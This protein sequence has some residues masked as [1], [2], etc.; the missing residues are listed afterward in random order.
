[1]QQTG[2][3]GRI[4]IFGV[5][6][7]IGI[8][9]A[10]GV[11]FFAFTKLRADTAASPNPAA[12]ADVTTSPTT[13][14]PTPNI[15]TSTAATTPSAHHVTT[16]ARGTNA[17]AAGSS[18][19]PVTI[20]AS[21]GKVARLTAT[22]GGVYPTAPIRD[23]ADASLDAAT[24]CLTK[25]PPPDSTPTFFVTVD[26]SGLVVDV[27]NANGASEP[28]NPSLDRCMVAVFQGLHL[29]KPDDAGWFRVSYAFP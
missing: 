4:A 6:A 9:V 11:A 19:T 1:M 16:A 23:R 28:R 18:S 3:G 10:I 7:L 22:V 24:A 15:S 17:A 12:V 13:V 5:L 26:A 20:G 14:V 2:G 25:F 8:F 29:G 27:G 21:H